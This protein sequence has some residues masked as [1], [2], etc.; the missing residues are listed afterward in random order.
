[1]NLSSSTVAGPVGRAEDVCVL[2]G[3]FSPHLGSIRERDHT[4]PPGAA[5]VPLA[6]SS[7]SPQQTEAWEL[8]N[9][10]NAVNESHILSSSLQVDLINFEF[11]CAWVLI[12]FHISNVG[13]LASLGIK[14][15][16]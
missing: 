10:K 2:S 11:H 13:T 16:H 14:L 5:A 1:M 3:L 12:E 4:Q 8:L 6:P 9:R 7:P 15:W